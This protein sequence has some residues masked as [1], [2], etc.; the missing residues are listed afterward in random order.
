MPP[1]PPQDLLKAGGRGALGRLG[2]PSRGC[3]ALA[4]VAHDSPPSVSRGGFSRLSPSEAHRRALARGLSW[5]HHGERKR[6]RRVG[7]LRIPVQLMESA[8]AGVLALVS[9]LLLLLAPSHVPGTVFVG[10]AVGRPHCPSRCRR[11][12]DAA[13]A[14][15]APQA[16][17]RV[18][19]QE[20]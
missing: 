5:G 1:T 3:R 4:A 6:D 20:R 9:A 13:A 14:E 17:D 12:A 11:S 10:A 15:K 8:M 19:D 7:T 16:P 2:R 18:H